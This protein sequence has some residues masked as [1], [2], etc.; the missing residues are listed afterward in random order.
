MIISGAA[1]AQANHILYEQ[2]R[3]Y[4]TF[5]TDTKTTEQFVDVVAC[6]NYMS[7]AYQAYN[8]AFYSG[9]KPNRRCA[10]ETR[11]TNDFIDDYI[12][13]TRTTKAMDDDRRIVVGMLVEDCYCGEDPPPYCPK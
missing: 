4:R 6:I 5:G 13:F 3:T 9:K 10:F 2:C 8:M 1:M 12:V 11:T 7:G